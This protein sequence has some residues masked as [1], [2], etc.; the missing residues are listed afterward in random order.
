LNK[1]Y[2][3][4]ELKAQLSIE[5]IYDLLEMWGGEPEYFSQGI[6][7][8][9]ICHN[10]PGVGSRKLY[11]YE[12]SQL[13][14]CFT[15]CTDSPSFDIFELCIKVVHNQKNME[16]QLYDAMNFIAQYFGFEGVEQVK[17]EEHLIGW[18]IFS[19]YK[20]KSKDSFSFAKL[21]SYDPVILTRFLYPR[22]LNWEDEG[23]SNEVI[24]KNLIG[25]YPGK[26]QITIPHFD[27]EG[28]LIGIRGRT[29]AQEEADRFGKYRP[30]IVE[31][32]MYNHPLSLNLYNLN[33][34]K[35][36]IRRAGVAIIFE[37]EKAC[38]QYISYYGQDNDISVA[39]CGSSISTY[40]IELLKSI[41]VQ[42]VVVA[43]DRDFECIG[44]KE[45]QRLKSKLIHI[46]D[47]YGQSIKISAI[48]DKEMILPHKASPIDAGPQI[49]EKLLKE[50]IVPKE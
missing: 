6:I 47:K 49:F 48:F 25:Y 8:Q 37:S 27:M 39:C 22:I 40:H 15:G 50:R 32:Q 46:N 7:S 2:N 12:G 34:S 18:E 24:K 14:Y 45:F 28:N 4:D 35:E 11:Y 21:P 5:N 1:F 26:E 41:G 13:F 42:E 20:K 38:L 23:I 16:W 43:F 9:T 36:N 33:N 30:L 44:D 31:G 3:K 29:L 17:E 10:L 19:R